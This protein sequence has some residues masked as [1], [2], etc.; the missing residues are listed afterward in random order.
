[1]REPSAAS[2]QSRLEP[3][4]SFRAMAATIA[5]GIRM[6]PTRAAPRHGAE[7]SPASPAPPPPKSASNWCQRSAL[8][9]A[10]QRTKLGAVVVAV[11]RRL[12]PNCSAVV[13]TKTAQ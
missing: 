11:A 7:G 3:K 13:V 2:V 8:P 4:D 12:V 9:A 6:A 5:T 1:M 10:D